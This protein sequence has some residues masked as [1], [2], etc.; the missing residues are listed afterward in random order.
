MKFP[1]SPATIAL[2]LVAHSLSSSVVDV[3]AANIAVATAG[4]ERNL[5]SGDFDFDSFEGLWEAT[6]LWRYPVVTG[7]DADNALAVFKCTKT[8]NFPGDYCEVTIKL[9]SIWGCAPSLGPALPD[10]SSAPCTYNNPYFSE[11]LGKITKDQFDPDTGRLVANLYQ[12]SAFIG[13]GCEST[14]S[15]DS[16]TLFQLK[17]NAGGGNGYA[18]SFSIEVAD[19]DTGEVFPPGSDCSSQNFYKI[20]GGF[21]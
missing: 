2:A 18:K 14:V 11:L 19:S 20:G 17:L 3:D 5:G 9:N 21:K 12:R 13:E 7:I 1:S 10:A 6:G 15:T 4:D 8:T 16:G